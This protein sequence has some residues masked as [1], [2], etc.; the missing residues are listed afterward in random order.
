MERSF[1]AEPETSNDNGGITVPLPD[2][3]EI[4][5]PIARLKY[6][7][8]TEADTLPAELFKHGGEEVTRW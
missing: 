2:F 1:S 8:A 5:M 6:Y 7:K 3:D 4:R